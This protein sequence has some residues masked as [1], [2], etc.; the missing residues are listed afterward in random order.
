[1]AKF[2]IKTQLVQ[3][4]HQQVTFN[5]KPEIPSKLHLEEVA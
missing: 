2:L 3:H 1:M 4:F 5:K